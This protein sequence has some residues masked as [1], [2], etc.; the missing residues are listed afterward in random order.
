M[1]HRLRLAFLLAVVY[2]SG[3]TS[4]LCIEAWRSGWVPDSVIV[5]RFWKHMVALALLVVGYFGLGTAQGKARPNW[6]LILLGWIAC[7]VTNYPNRW[8]QPMPPDLAGWNLMFFG[9]AAVVPFYWRSH[10]VLHFGSYAY[11]FLINAVLQQSPFAEVDVGT[12][13]TGGVFIR[14]I[15]ATAVFNPAKFTAGTEAIT[16]PAY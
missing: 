12:V 4:I 10:L 15:I 1:A 16:T 3:W 9:A 8:D 6:A 13:G 11:H 14:T 2:F 7:I 5:V